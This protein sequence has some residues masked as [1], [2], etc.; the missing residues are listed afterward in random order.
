MELGDG[1]RLLGVDLLLD[2]LADVGQAPFEGVK[3]LAQPLGL[4][5]QDLAAGRHVD[6]AHEVEQ[7]GLTRARR[8]RDG[9]E[10]ASLDGEIDP[11]ESLSVTRR[12]WADIVR[13]ADMY[14][15][16]GSFTTFVAYEYTTSS[17]DQGNL[18]RNVVFKGS[19]RVPEVP[20]SRVHSNNPED[21]WD[22]MDTLRAAGVESMAIPHNSNVSNSAMFALHT[23][24]GNPIDKRWAERSRRNTPAVEMI[25]TKG[26]SETHP[27]LSPND[28][29]AGFEDKFTHLL[30]S[31]GVLGLVDKSFVRN[32]LIDGVGFQ[33]MLGANPFKYGIVAGADSHNAASVN[34]EFNY[35]GVHGNTDK[36]AEIRLN[37]PGSLGKPF[38]PD[39]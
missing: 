15:Q 5:D 8:A 18:H 31:G 26:A 33:E 27:A 17:D 4:A 12:A 3:A 39:G 22:W 23:S 1:V 11:E 29:F 37:A 32:A 2:S 38:H 30:G 19:D 16:P 7:R 6:A 21:L 28:E 34:E 36:S 24:N 10:V 13:A 14:Y 20:F 35:T 9:G 25:Q